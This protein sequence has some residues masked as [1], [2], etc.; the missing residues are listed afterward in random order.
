MADKTLPRIAD[1]TELTA[2]F[3]VDSTNLLES[4][5]N[6][7]DE[8]ALTMMEFV[9]FQRSEA[10]RAQLAANNLADSIKQQGGDS[11]APASDNNT[12]GDSSFILADLGL[13]GQGFAL[14]VGAT[15]GVVQGQIEVIRTFAKAAK[16]L[17]PKPLLNLI[18]GIKTGITSAGSALRAAVKSGVDDLTK[19]LSGGITRIKSLLG[20]A[21]DSSFV[22][23]IRAAVNSGLTRLTSIFSF[24]D[25]TPLGKVVSALRNSVNV[26]VKPFKAAFSMIKSMV[27]PIQTV[28]ETA[29]SMFSAF[30]DMGGL[31]KGIARVVKTIFV[32]LGI[33]MTAIDTVKGIITGFREGGIV[34]ALE[35]GITGFFTSIIGAPLD[36]LKKGVEFVLGVFGFDNAKSTLE[37]FSFSQLISDSIGA[38]FDVFKGAV[39]WVKNLVPDVFGALSEKWNT[40]TGGQGL[41][42]LVMRPINGFIDWVKTLF[43]DPREAL[44]QLWQTALGGYSNLLD[45]VFFPINKA[46]DW[47]R[48]IFGWSDPEDDEGFSVGKIVTDAINGVVQWLSGIFSI[49]NITTKLSEA[50]DFAQSMADVVTDAWNGIKDWLMEKLSSLTDFLPSIDDIKTSLLNKLPS[51][52]IPDSFKTPEMRAQE[53]QGRISELEGAIE[54][55]SW[56]SV[57]RS[58]EDERR[59]LEEARR[60]LQELQSQ[61]GG[62][63][64]ATI[65]NNV[66]GGTTTNN[67]SATA[68]PVV[69]EVPGGSDGMRPDSS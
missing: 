13:L 69:V 59:E 24:A 52:M 27:K 30:G 11:D 45:I 33:V 53:I 21:D 3:T 6:S 19:S 22:S 26:I 37:G 49:E 43:S 38:I 5:S 40:L 39:D 8:L 55:D 7:I 25:D 12:E 20:F 63:A 10:I 41:M 1:S 35:G 46:V 58:S 31:I 42:D 18:K 44:Q 23:G 67:S 47:V 64:N 28:S 29:G 2:E 16:A 68:N 54:E 60:E 34:G 14:L 51:W 48:G 15:I 56:R 32:P 17:T 62:G 61:N 65:V 66:Q 9:E 4:I 57:G 50:V 36:L